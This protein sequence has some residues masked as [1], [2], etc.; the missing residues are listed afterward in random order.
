VNKD[1]QEKTG[2]SLYELD[3]IEQINANSDEKSIL[4]LAAK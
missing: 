2:M 1:V 3:I 4:F